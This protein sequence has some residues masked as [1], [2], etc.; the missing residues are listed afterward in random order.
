MVAAPSVGAVAGTGAAS[1]AAQVDPE[2]GEATRAHRAQ[3][4]R[5][6]SKL[7]RNFH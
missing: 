7:R 1:G 4:E 3:L 2:A 5:L 6:R